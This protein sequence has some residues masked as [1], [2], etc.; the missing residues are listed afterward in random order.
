MVVKHFRKRELQKEKITF[1]EL[2][3]L[4]IGLAFGWF[5][6]AGAPALI[7]LIPVAFLAIYAY[8]LLVGKKRR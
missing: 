5:A 8:E 7:L 1:M 2:I 6:G 3:W 4:L